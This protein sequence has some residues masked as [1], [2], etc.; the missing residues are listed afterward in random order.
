M[1]MI[2]SYTSKKTKFL[3]CLLGICLDYGYSQSIM[4]KRK[5]V[6]LFSL[7]LDGHV[8]TLKGI[9]AFSFPQI[10][11]E[12]NANKRDPWENAIIKGGSFV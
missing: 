2:Q 8:F 7:V 12:E 1:V 3:F 6:Y 11:C 4:I 5:C 10:N 9:N